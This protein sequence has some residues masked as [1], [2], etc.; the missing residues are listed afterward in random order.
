MCR[1][2]SYDYFDNCSPNINNSYDASVRERVER[3]SRIDELQEIQKEI[4][5]V[6]CREKC[7]VYEA[8]LIIIQLTEQ[9][10]KLTQ[11]K[12]PYITRVGRNDNKVEFVTL[13]EQEDDVVANSIQKI[14]NEIL[15]DIG[16]IFVR[17]KLFA[18]ECEMI[19]VALEEII[20]RNCRTR[21]KGRRP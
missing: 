8:H 2:P 3:I 17:E 7:T 10:H 19:L 9:I 16:D 21:D 14:V 13:K 6:F 11:G 18:P 12:D 20:K 15:E 5:G 1:S 4:V